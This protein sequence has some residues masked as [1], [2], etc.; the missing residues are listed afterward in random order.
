MPDTKDTKKDFVNWMK[1]H[2]YKVESNTVVEEIIKKGIKSLGL[3][4]NSVFDENDSIKI[5]LLASELVLK[6]SMFDIRRF[7]DYKKTLILLISYAEFLEER[8]KVISEKEVSGQQKSMELNKTNDSLTIAYYLSR[9]DKIAVHELG[10]KSF[11]EA[12]DKLGVI[13]EQK[14]S[15]IKNMRDE[16]DPYF[17]NGR[18]G[19]YQ[20]QLVGSRKEVFELYKN[21]SDEEVAEAVREIISKYNQNQNNEKTKGHKKIII[22]SDNMKEYKA[23][24]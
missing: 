6:K 7:D 24:K 4:L 23:K 8:N 15:T 13:L 21:A 1:K 18:V 16:F 12:F 20:K 3:G 22:S 11:R 2:N 14:P 10:Y 9:V 17:D 19:W 5:R